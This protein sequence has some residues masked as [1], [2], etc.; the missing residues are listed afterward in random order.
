MAIEQPPQI[1]MFEGA[2]PGQSMIASP[3]SKMKWDGPPKYAG[4][5]EASEAMFL[6]LLEPETLK[7]IVTL[8]QRDIPVSEITSIVLITGFSEGKYNPDLLMMLI[9]P[10]M[11]FIMA[12]A[13]RFGI[14]P[15]IYKGEEEEYDSDMDSD[16]SAEENREDI[17]AGIQKLFTNKNTSPNLKNTI[18]KSEIAQKL[19]AIDTES[20]MAKPEEEPIPTNLLEQRK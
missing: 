15:K 3:E 5:R 8:L 16:I 2:I 9:E 19:A 20:L 13:D 1:N 6:E 4:F 18:S 17:G 14:D 10:T 11:Y 7:S 12:I